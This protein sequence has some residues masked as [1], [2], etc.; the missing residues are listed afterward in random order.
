[1]SV[2]YCEIVLT[3]VTIQA[4]NLKS[5]LRELE[6]EK[7]ILLRS[8]GITPK[9]I[10]LWAL[11]NGV[12]TVHDSIDTLRLWCG[13]WNVAGHEPLGGLEKT[14]AYAVIRAFVPANDYDVYVLAVQEAVSDSLLECLDGLLGA[15]GLQRLALDTFSNA[16]HTTTATSGSSGSDRSRLFMRGDG[17]LQF[18]KFIG[19]AVYVHRKLIGDTRILNIVSKCFTGSA[20]RGAVAAAISVLGRTFVFISAQLDSKSREFRRNQGREIA[21]DLGDLLG[22]KGFHLNE[23]FHHII[24]VGDFGSPI[25]DTSGL[26]MPADTTLKMLEDGLART[27]F[28]SHDELNKEKKSQQL[29]YK[30]REPCPYPNF[31][32]TYKKIE[33]RSPLDFSNNSWVR[34]T[35]DTLVKQPFFKGGAVKESPPSFADRVLYH[36]MVDLAEDL[37]PEPM[38]QHMVVHLTEV[39]GVSY[40]NYGV[41]KSASFS[42]ASTSLVAATP[43]RKAGSVADTLSPPTAVS[44]SS[45]LNVSMKDVVL[46]NYRSVNDGDCMNCS[47]HSPVFATFLLRLRHD[48][49]GFRNKPMAAVDS[50]GNVLTALHDTASEFGVSPRDRILFGLSPTVES[51]LSKRMQVSCSAGTDEK[52]SSA[53]A[54]GLQQPAKKTPPPVSGRVGIGA[55]FADAGEASRALRGYRYSLLP[56]AQYTIRIS[57]FKLIWGNH[58]EMP[59]YMKLLFPAPYE[60]YRTA[61]F[62][63]D[64]LCSFSPSTEKRSPN[65]FVK[66]V[67][68]REIMQI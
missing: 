23:Q 24:C 20:T 28:E 17:P 49:E 40:A 61:Y 50:I 54:L 45:R 16:T 2:P 4:S 59:A 58:E 13:T 36:S 22:E 37:V 43:P 15:A 19:L 34:S 41:S 25:V 51:E 38:P 7:N 26:I 52:S 35:Y 64:L 39:D 21:A 62:C 32:P 5:R 47:T 56:P 33:N 18:Q 12:S 42:S 46:D 67:E 31:F 66:L 60:V 9:K 1:V 57:N 3:R 27:L 11:E 44:Q 53:L 8:R 30:Y 29:F 10:P 55:G 63:R 48:Y 65:F 68:P 6:A 14:K